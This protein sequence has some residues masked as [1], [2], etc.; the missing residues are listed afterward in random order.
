MKIATIQLSLNETT[1]IKANNIELSL[2]RAFSSSIQSNTT[3]E[4]GENQVK[5][6]SFCDLVA[7]N[8]SECGDQVIIQRVIYFQYLYSMIVLFK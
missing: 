7:T 6:P 4:L 2:K 8:Q 5:M 3:L 1:E